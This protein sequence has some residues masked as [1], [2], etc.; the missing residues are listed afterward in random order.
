MMIFHVSFK[1]NGILTEKDLVCQGEGGNIE[2]CFQ[3]SGVLTDTFCRLCVENIGKGV[4]WKIVDRVDN[5]YIGE[6]VE[7]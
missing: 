1:K 7:P 3:S 5:V 6:I 4:H 2:F